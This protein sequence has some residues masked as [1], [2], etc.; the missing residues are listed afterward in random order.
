MKLSSSDGRSSI[1][2]CDSSGANAVRGDATRKWWL[3]PD[4]NYI[5][6]LNRYTKELASEGMPWDEAY[7]WGQTIMEAM[8]NIKQKE[9]DNREPD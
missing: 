6:Q 7:S 3:M 4:L 1:E 9:I 2:G 5:Y 8:C